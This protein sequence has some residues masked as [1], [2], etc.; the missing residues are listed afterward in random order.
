MSK[1][2]QFKEFTIEQDQCAMKIGTDGVLLGAW[3]TVKNEFSI[4]DLGTGTGVISLML[5]QRSNAEVIEAIEIDGAAFEQAVSNFENSMWSDRLS[6]YHA[7]LHEFAKEIEEKYELIISNPPFYTD[8][9]PSTNKERSIARFEDAM[10]F[11]HLANAA[12]YLLDPNG[13]FAIIIPYKEEEKFVS[14]AKENNLFLNRVCRVKG[15]EK[16]PIK[17]SL[18]EFSFKETVIT[19][20]NLTIETERHVYTEDYKQ[21]V[22]DFYLKM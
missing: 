15:N 17:R 16:S 6:C 5:A 10:P 19:E 7:S 1:P 4:L 13:I 14:L 18:L 2:F 8:A 9:N 22:Q 20:E 11:S 3:T 12:A 21:L